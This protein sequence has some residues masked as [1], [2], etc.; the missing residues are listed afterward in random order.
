MV[1]RSLIN[2]S[3]KYISHP[4]KEIAFALIILGPTNNANQIVKTKQY[5]ISG[6][7]RSAKT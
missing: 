5:A 1:G 2:D 3:K 7:H 6:T 4:I